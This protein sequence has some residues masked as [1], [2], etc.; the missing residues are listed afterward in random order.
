MVFR[1]YRT[2]KTIDLLNQELNEYGN[3]GQELVN[4]TFRSFGGIYHLVF[5]RDEE[6]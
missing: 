5:K 4:F 2:D 1:K 6:Q 3:D